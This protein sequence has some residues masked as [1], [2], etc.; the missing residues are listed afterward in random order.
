MELHWRGGSPKRFQMMTQ[1]MGKNNGKCTCMKS[2]QQQHHHHHHQP[3]PQTEFKRVLS[4]VRPSEKTHAR[5][6]L[7]HTWTAN[8][9]S[10]RVGR[11][12]AIEVRVPFLLAER[13]NCVLMSSSATRNKKDGLLHSE[14]FTVVDITHHPFCKKQTSLSISFPKRACL[15][16][17]L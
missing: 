5:R 3:T 11:R 15:L 16:F 8:F 14:T 9:F 1:N 2:S 4:V 13:C 12:V 6:T 17:P 10:G 7:T